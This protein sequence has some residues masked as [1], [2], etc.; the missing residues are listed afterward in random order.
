MESSVRVDDLGNTPVSSS[1]GRATALAAAMLLVVLLTLV[2]IPNAL[3]GYLTT[4]V[5]PNARDL[6]V[7]A[8]WMVGFVLCCVLFLRLQRRSGG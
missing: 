1:W 7:V 4:R 3:L 2:L 6:I 8:V 5:T